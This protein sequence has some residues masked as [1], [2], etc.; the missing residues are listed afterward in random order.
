M[1]PALKPSYI[2]LMILP[3]ISLGK[4][5]LNRRVSCSNGVI[6]FLLKYQS[7][8]KERFHIFVHLRRIGCSSIG[9]FLAWM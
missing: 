6:F 4:K 9:P 5:Q 8:Q 7:V 1:K 2:M 3:I